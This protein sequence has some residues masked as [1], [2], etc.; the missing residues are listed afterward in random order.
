MSSR[1]REEIYTCVGILLFLFA[2]GLYVVWVYYGFL[3]FALGAFVILIFGVYA[4]YSSR[5]QKKNK[6]Q[7]TNQPNFSAMNNASPEQR[8]K[9]MELSG[10]TKYT[11]EDGSIH[12]KPPSGAIPEWAKAEKIDVVMKDGSLEIEVEKQSPKIRCSY[13]GTVYEEKLDRCPNCGATRQG[14]E[15]QVKESTL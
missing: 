12:W 14:N 10:F 2:I 4:V 1:A 11:A 8:E 9:M 5:K 15:E 7:T 13:C 6:P 3:P